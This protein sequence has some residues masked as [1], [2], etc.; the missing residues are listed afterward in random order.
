MNY[1]WS[2]IAIF[3]KRLYFFIQ[4]KN[5]ILTEIGVIWPGK[6]FLKPE[7]FA[8]PLLNTLTTLAKTYTAIWQAIQYDLMHTIKERPSL[9]VWL[10]IFYILWRSSLFSQRIVRLYIAGKAN[11]DDRLYSTTNIYKCSAPKQICCEDHILLRHKTCLVHD[12]FS[13]FWCYTLFHSVIG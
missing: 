9:I 12:R 6:G 3:Q 1:S 11:W 2:C 4:I 10:L 8:I 13:T 7:K 5:F